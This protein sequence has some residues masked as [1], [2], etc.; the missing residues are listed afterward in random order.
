MATVTGWRTH[1]EP[2]G[3]Y[4]A[5]VYEFA[6]QVPETVLKRATFATR[7]RAEGWARKWVR[8]L[9]ANARSSAATL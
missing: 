2:T 5:I 9:R 8:F 1:K 6:Y 7:A 3:I 4:T